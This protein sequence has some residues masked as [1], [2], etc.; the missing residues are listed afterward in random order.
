MLVTLIHNPTA[1]DQDEDGK[2]LK[3]LLRK[4]GHEVRYRS[5]KEDGWK[6]ALKK[7]ADLVVVAGGD[8]TVGRVARRMAG[9]SIPMA[10]LP[11]GTANNI[12]RSLGQHERP[13]EE[14][15]AA[16]EGA[17]R[18]KLDVGTAKGPWGTRNF[19]EALGFGVFAGHLAAF[20]DVDESKAKS[21]DEK[22]DQ[23]LLRMKR[24]AES[25]EA[26]HVSATLDGKDLSGNYLLMEAMNLHYVG[27]NMRLALE[28]MP[29]DGEFEVVLVTE[30]ERTRFV[31]YLEAWRENRERLAVL[32]SH[33]GK[34]LKIEWTGFPL[35]IDDKL[36]PKK[37]PEPNEIAGVVEAKING[38]S[39][40]FLL[41]Q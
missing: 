31:Q 34:H 3:K 30:E 17:P 6:K 14:L 28:G 20:E 11:L 24:A 5:A 41:P 16:W 33:R 19:I 25:A 26:V 7:P 23:A 13:L 35:H 32:P 9:L 39:V 36:Y 8:G 1:G 37:N 4:A 38:T 18:A 40:D 27:P 12:A 22:V 10:V 21:A 2:S 29:G 15:V